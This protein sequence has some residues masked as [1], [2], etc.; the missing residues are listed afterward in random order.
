MIVGQPKLWASDVER[1]DLF[2]KTLS[3][4]SDRRG[5]ASDVAAEFPKLAR[6]VLPLPLP[7]GFTIV[8]QPES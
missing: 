2:L 1:P 7:P 8:L 5:C 3:F 4:E 6:K